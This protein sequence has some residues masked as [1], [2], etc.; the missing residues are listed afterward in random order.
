MPRKRKVVIVI[1]G[2]NL[3]GT[4]IDLERWIDFQRLKE[5]WESKYDVVT[6][7]YFERVRDNNSEFVQYLRWLGYDVEMIEGTDVD[8][9]MVEYIKQLDCK[10]ARTILSVAGDY[11]YA[12]PL[13]KRLHKGQKVI[14]LSGE[15][16]LSRAYY[17]LG[18]E[19]ILL[20]NIIDQFSRVR[21]DK[22][23]FITDDE[24]YLEPDIPSP[25]PVTSTS[26][27]AELG[28]PV[29]AF[30]DDGLTDEERAK[31]FGIVFGQY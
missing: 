28:S 13:E 8:D 19:I 23:D 3:L 11:I 17:N 27:M 16:Q 21:Y 2:P 7:K 24:I 20:D 6:I 22:F 30:V 12:E 10:I 18:F 14:V 4:S 9:Y 26:T 1:D 25:G 15:E 29:T 5:Y 31:K